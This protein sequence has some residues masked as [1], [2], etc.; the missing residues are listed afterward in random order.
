MRSVFLYTMF[1]LTGVGSVFVT[2]LQ[3][4][5]YQ[6]H[7]L[8]W[9]FSFVSIVMLF[10]TGLDFPVKYFLLPHH[11]GLSHSISRRPRST[12]HSARFAMSVVTGF[13]LSEITDSVH[14]EEPLNN[15]HLGESRYGI[16]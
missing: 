13:D 3:F 6:R 16:L 9:A 14:I 12:G 11:F 4:R 10:L 7:D 2:M 8:P 5:T 1:G 15:N